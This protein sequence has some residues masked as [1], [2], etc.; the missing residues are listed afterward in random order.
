MIGEVSS[1]LTMFVGGEGRRRGLL[2]VE[3]QQGDLVHQGELRQSA[4]Y[5]FS[6]LLLQNCVDVVPEH[7]FLTPHFHH[8]TPTPTWHVWRRVSSPASW[9]APGH[10]VLCGDCRGCRPAALRRKIWVKQRDKRPGRTHLW[11]LTVS[12]SS[13]LASSEWQF[14][15]ALQPALR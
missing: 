5:N 11:A 10:W 7:S 9:E 13:A 8:T 14:W 2:Q 12:W 4:L 6:R 1:E 3:E 15:W